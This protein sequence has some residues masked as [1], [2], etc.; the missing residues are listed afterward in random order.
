MSEPDAAA[1][2]ELRDEVTALKRQL[3]VERTAR[4]A[5]VRRMLTVVLTA[6]AV[7]AMTAALLAVWTFRTLTDTDLFVARVGPVIEQPEVAAAIG[8][9]A[10]A[11]LVDGRASKVA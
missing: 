9:A 2:D 7:L 11:Q 4:A 10:A 1:I 5:R 6:S 8:E 3:A